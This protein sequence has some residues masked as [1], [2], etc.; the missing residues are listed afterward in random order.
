MYT[1]GRLGNQIIRNLALSLIAEKFDLYVIYSH[2]DLIK[3]LG[4]QLFIGNNNYDTI[5]TLND[6]NYIETLQSNH[7]NSNLSVSSSYFQTNEICNL[8]YEYL[9]REEIKTN[10]INHNRFKEK[11]NTNNDVFIHIRLTDAERFNPGLEYYLKTISNISF[12]HLYISTDD[13]HNHIVRQITEKYNNSTIVDY[14][15][16]T[17]FQFGSSCK[18]V[19]LSHGSFSA[20]IGYLSFFSNV[21][22]PEYDPNKIWYGDMFSINGWNKVRF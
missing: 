7:L 8:L 2:Y 6:N 16:I 13:K 9:H 22:Y 12:D 18:N 4:I 5:Q 14:D 3:Q 21:Y 19:I 11:Y 20:I 1:S 17:T 10:I 15:E